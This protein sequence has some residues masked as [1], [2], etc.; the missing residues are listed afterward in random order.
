[1]SDL[2]WWQPLQMALGSLLDMMPPE[3]R[4]ATVDQLKLAAQACENKGNMR[5]ANFCRALTGESYEAPAPKPKPAHLKL[6]K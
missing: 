6:I 4:A 2:D 3:Q 5:G 1:V